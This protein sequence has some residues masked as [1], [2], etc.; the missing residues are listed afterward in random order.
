MPLRFLFRRS[1]GLAEDERQA[2]GRV[3]SQLPGALLPRPRVISARTPERESDPLRQR[4][5]AADPG[6]VSVHWLV[7]DRRAVEKIEGDR[8]FRLVGGYQ[9]LIE[10]FLGQLADA[11][12]TVQTSA[13]VEKIEWSDGRAVVS[14]RGK[15][16]VFTIEVSRALITV[17]LGVLQSGPGSEGSIRFVPALPNS[18]VEAL[19]KLEMGKV[20]RVVLVFRKRFWDGLKGEDSRTLEEMSFLLSRDDDFPTW[21]TLMPSKVPVITGWAPAHS[22]ER[23]SGQAEALVVEQAL[24]TLSELLGISKSDLEAWL[25]SANFHDWQNDPFSR[26]AY[27]YAKVGADGAQE[28]LAAP[29][30]DTL[31]FAGEATNLYGHDGTVHG[32]IETGVRA[33]AEILLGMEKAA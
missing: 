27:S 30:A 10:I 1:E 9:S 2:T 7:R 26:G 11:G 12:V 8:S 3:V 5:N 24:R 6:R 18:K 21:W 22:A 17:P 32:A 14:G 31:F 33:A 4:I 20:I 25:A 28:V 13:V 29:L 19:G 15:D 16:G 23:L